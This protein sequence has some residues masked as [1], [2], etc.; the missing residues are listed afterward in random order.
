MLTSTYGQG[1]APSNANLFLEKL[2]QINIE[3]S[4]KCSVIG[5]G[6]YAYPQFCEFAKDI[7]KSIINIRNVE[8]VDTSALLI[9]NQNY[10]EF[11]N[12]GTAW[13]QSIHLNLVFPADVISKKVKSSTFKIVSKKV[14]Q[15]AYSETFTLTLVPE[16]TQKFTSGDL[17]G[18]TPLEDNQE[19]LYSMGQNAEGNILLSIKKHTQ[20]ICS[21]YL[22]QLQI[23]DKLKANI[24]ENKSFHFPKKASSV[25]LIA[26][27]TGIA[28]FLGMIHQKTKADVTLYFGTRTKKSSELYETSISEA[29]KN[30]TLHNYYLSLSKEEGRCKYVQDLLWR[31]E[32]E[33]ASKL[34]DGGVFMLCGSLLMRDSVFETLENICTKHQLQPLRFYQNKH[35]ILTDCY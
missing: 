6:S 5:F 25:I 1:E 15:D 32:K 26:N 20:G 27:G 3:K 21:T 11:K 14:I 30:K 19:R 16:K 24:Q 17:L 9:H 33:I 35:K 13:G 23:D 4:F 12:W 34:Q 29:V 28:P 8:P 7:H 10:Q 18:V 2:K 31:D 22:H